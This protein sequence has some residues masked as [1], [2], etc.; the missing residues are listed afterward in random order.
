LF[1]NTCSTVVVSVNSGGGAELRRSRIV[2]ESDSKRINSPTEAEQQV[3]PLPSATS[4]SVFSTT[5]RRKIRLSRLE[6]VIKYSLVYI[7]FIF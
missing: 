1:R 5:G 7:L 4:S 3:N 6:L 2:R